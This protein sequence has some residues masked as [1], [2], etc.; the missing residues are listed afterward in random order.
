MPKSKIKEQWAAILWEKKNNEKRNKKAMLCDIIDLACI[1]KKYRTEGCVASLK[2]VDTSTG[3]TSYH[4]AK[5]LKISS[6][7]FSMAL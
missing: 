7:Y 1:P 6:K 2:W 4:K 5:V 3:K